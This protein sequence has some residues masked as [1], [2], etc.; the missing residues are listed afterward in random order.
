VRR[1][2]VILHDRFGIIVTIIAVVGAL[3]ATL[4]LLR[5]RLLPVVRTYLR[6]EVGVVVVQVLIGLVLVVTG[7]RP[8]QLL[9]WFYGAATLV[10]LPLALFIGG[11]RSDR[12]EP[13]WVMGG[14]VATLLFAFRAITTG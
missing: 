5:P 12:E 11:S 3:I 7:Q 9:H 2:A 14:A 13:L 4:A 10:A 6:L 8:Q 1:A